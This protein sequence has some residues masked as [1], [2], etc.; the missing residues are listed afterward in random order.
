MFYKLSDNL[1][2]RLDHITYIRKNT[3]VQ[4]RRE[5]RKVHIINL[6]NG[7]HYELDVD[8]VTDAQIEFI[9]NQIG[10]INP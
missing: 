1:F 3:V 4:G 10:V 2:I 6:S 7:K 9:M 5:D 8:P